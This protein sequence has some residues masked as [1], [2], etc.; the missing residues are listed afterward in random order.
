RCQCARRASTTS[1]SPGPA[2]TKSPPRRSA[3]VLARA[4]SW[5]SWSVVNRPVVAVTGVTLRCSLEQGAPGEEYPFMTISSSPGV[6]VV[7]RIHDG[8]LT[9]D[10]WRI[11]YC[12]QH[13]GSQAF[14]TCCHGYVGQMALGIP[15]IAV[16]YRAQKPEDDI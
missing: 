4:T 1:G 10:K 12:R 13:H 3:S 16:C 9:S 5:R 14:A 6:Q 15:E 7:L 11:E 8:Y 2:G